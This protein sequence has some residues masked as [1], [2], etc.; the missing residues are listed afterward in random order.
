MSTYSGAV[1][2]A[3]NGAPAWS[4]SSSDHPGIALVTSPLVGSNFISWSLAIKTVLGAKDKLGFIDRT[5]KEPEDE[6]EFKKWKSVDSMVKSW[7]RNSMAKELAES[8]MFCRTSGELWKELEEIYGVKSGPKFYQLQQDLSSLR[9]GSDSVTTYFNKIHRFWDEIH[10][11]RPIPRC[12]CAKCTCAFN[13]KMDGLEA[14][15]KL[16]Q[17]LMGLNQTF[18]MIRSQILALDPLPSVNKAFAMVVTVEIEKEINQVQGSSGIEGS[19]MMARSNPRNE[20]FKKIEDRR[21]EK[22]AKHCDYCQQNGH[23]REGCFKLIGYPEWFKELREQRKKNGKKNMAATAISETPIDLT[24]DKGTNDYARVMVALQ[25]LTKIVK[26]KTEQKHVNFANLGEFAGKNGGKETFPF[27]TNTSWVVDTGA[28]SHMCSNKELLINLRALDQEIPVHLPDG[29]VK[30][31]K[32]TESVD[33]KSSKTLVEGRLTDNLYILKHYLD[34]NCATTNC[35]DSA[36][37]VNST[38]TNNK[39]TA[40]MP[41]VEENSESNQEKNLMENAEEHNMNN[42]IE[43]PF[44]ETQVEESGQG[45]DDYMPLSDDLTDL[46][47]EEQ[48]TN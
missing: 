42:D 20:N 40:E 48:D 8:F 22:L 9:Q 37:S 43:E 2:G 31:V 41:L 18:E 7:V 39:R 30:N 12:T 33:L 28:S 26:G 15:T 17:F 19:A 46:V 27:F 47:A 45:S 38:Y 4:L 5:V 29:S 35:L 23:T 11:L 25:E 16:V 10:R 32:H 34:S 44:I 1:S 13:K 14:D 36:N 3:K 24:N 21:N 6:S